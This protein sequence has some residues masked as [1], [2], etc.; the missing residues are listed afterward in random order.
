MAKLL[1]MPTAFRQSLFASNSAMRGLSGVLL[2]AM[3]LGFPAGSRLLLQHAHGS[4]PAH[5]HLT[6]VAG[7]AQ[8]L[9]GHHNGLSTA[10][11]SAH[12]SEHGDSHHLLITDHSGWP[13]GLALVGGVSP[14]RCLRRSVFPSN[15]HLTANLPPPSLY[16][17]DELRTQSHIFVAYTLPDRFRHSRMSARLALTARFLL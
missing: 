12:E 10:R 4:E 11:C 1:V 17:L 14:D 2:L 16:V 3:L 6:S 15:W 13:G 8:G 9:P 7:A 5:R